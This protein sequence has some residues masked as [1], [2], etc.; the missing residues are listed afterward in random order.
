MFYATA[1]ANVSGSSVT[2]PIQAVAAGSAGNFDAN[3]V[4]LISAP[5]GGIQSQSNA[6][7]QTTAGTDQELDDAL[8]TRMLRIYAAP[9]QGGDLQDYIE[10]ATSV[11]GVTRA[12]V[13]QNSVGPGTVSVY[14]M[15]D[16]ADA[17][18]GGFPQGTNGVAT[19]EPRDNAATGDQLT[20][21]D[22]LFPLRPVTALVYALAP[23]P[24]PV[25]FTIADLGASNTTA[26]QT[27]IAAA[28]ADMF[29]RLGNVG[30]TVVPSTGAA[31]PAIEPDAW[32][33][34]LEAIPGLAGFKVTAPTGAI[35]PATGAL[36]TVVSLTF[37]T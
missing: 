12:W 30:G 31:W 28:L 13:A 20:I 8:R 25:A 36:F 15:M 21:A 7:A 16:L 24:S 29:V 27:A 11:P 26:M 23:T 2:V 33:A 3:T 9:P 1:N 34:A 32:Y 18:Y 37:V 17:T 19:N 6:S 14:F 4:F 10:W 22:A 35:T 5:I